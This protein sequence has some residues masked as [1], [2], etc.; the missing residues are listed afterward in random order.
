[1]EMM[2]ATEKLSEEQNRESLRK[3][4]IAMSSV[5]METVVKDTLSLGYSNY[6]EESFMIIFSCLDNVFSDIIKSNH[7]DKKLKKDLKFLLKI[8]TQ[9]LENKIEEA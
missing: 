6:I 5:C 9:W 8:Y 7:T 1:M 4:I 2:V 3:S